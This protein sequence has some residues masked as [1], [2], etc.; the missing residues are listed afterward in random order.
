MTFAAGDYLFLLDDD[1]SHI[2]FKYNINTNQITQIDSL[3]IDNITN[4]GYLEFAE[5]N[6]NLKVAKM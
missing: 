2:L 5:F 1:G 6:T 3:Q 4:N